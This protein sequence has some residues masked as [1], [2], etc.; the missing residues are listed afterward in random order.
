M[1]YADTQAL[2]ASVT[3]DLTQLPEE[4]LPLVVEFV[5]YLRQRKQT[6][7]AQQL[8]VADIRTEAR[9]RAA[10]LQSLPRTEVVIRFQ[11]LAD[12]IRQDVLNRGTGVMSDYE[13]D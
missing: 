9:R 4:D 13:G 7:P 11:Q 12:E 1:T 3:Q 2:I 6:I 10:L 5:H 8:S